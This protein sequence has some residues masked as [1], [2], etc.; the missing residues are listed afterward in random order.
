MINNELNIIEPIR[1][2]LQAAGYKEPTAIQKEAIPHL[3]AGRDLLA[4]AQT[5][6]GKTAAFAIP[7]LQGLSYEPRATQSNPNIKALILVPTRELAMQIGNSFKTYGKHLNLKTLVV[8]GGVSQHPQTKQLKKGVDILVAT[9]GRLLDLM[10]Q[11]HIRLNQV[12][13]FVLDEADMMLDMGMLA[14]VK[15]IVKHIPA[16][17]QTMCFSATMPKEIAKLTDIILKDPLRIEVAPISSTA[18]RIK[19]E[20]YYVDPGNKTKLLV[21]LLRDPAVE[22]AIVF[23]RTKHGADKIVKSLTKEG[24]KAK[25]IHGNKSQNVRQR[26]LR[27]LKERKINILV[28][29]DVAAR[30]LDISDLSHVINYNLTE[31]AETY[32]HRIGRT[33][34]AGDEGIAISLVDHG[35]KGFLRNIEKL[36]GNNIPVNNDHDY[37]LQDKT[38]QPPGRGGRSRGRSGKKGGGRR[39]RNQKSNQQG[40]RRRKGQGQSQGKGQGKKRPNNRNKARGKKSNPRG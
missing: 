32:V 9:P 27:E 3:L 17:R 35:E 4:S 36:T 16:K 39:G 14:D 34:R 15:R 37:P 22:S 38:V 40:Q 10:N 29:T 21:E 26:T 24:F 25:A 30:G 7:I 2:S 8:F 19:Q 31:V 23:S 6:T 12:Q 33:G 1:K 28:A 18:D 13:Y 5:G 11:K 20:V